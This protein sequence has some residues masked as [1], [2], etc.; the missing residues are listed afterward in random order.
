MEKQNQPKK[1]GRPAKPKVIQ[2]EPVI[3]NSKMFF[4]SAEIVTPK[5]SYLSKQDDDGI[6]CHYARFHQPVPPSLNKEPVSEFKT[7]RK[8]INDKYLVD[9]MNL[10]PIG[11]VFKSKD[12]TNVVPLANIIYVRT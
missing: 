8:E 5:H 2:E 10:T 11:L 3:H 9:S 4:E 12:E 6:P 1:R 7:F